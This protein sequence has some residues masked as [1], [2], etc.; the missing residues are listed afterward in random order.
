MNK[1]K[2]GDTEDT[3]VNLSHA[4]RAKLFFL[5]ALRVSMLKNR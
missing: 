3:E 1:M 4:L 2:H 5:G